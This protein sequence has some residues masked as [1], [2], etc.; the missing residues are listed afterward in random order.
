MKF[1][2]NPNCPE[3]A[4]ITEVH[5]AKYGSRCCFF[6]VFCARDLLANAPAIEDVLILNADP[7]KAETAQ[8]YFDAHRW[9]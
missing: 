5:Q 8:K 4:E 6:P 9:T 2:T 3:G 7:S 1:R